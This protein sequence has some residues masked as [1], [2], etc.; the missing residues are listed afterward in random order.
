MIFVTEE[1]KA[2][3]KA[4]IEAET[5]NFFDL[6]RMAGIDPKTELRNTDL[7]GVDFTG[8]DLRGCDL[9]GSNLRNATGSQ[10]IW[11]STTNLTG[12]DTRGSIFEVAA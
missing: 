1:T 7:E 5:D 4:L 6:C 3:M 2:Q 8:C 9:S 10:A 12:A 11:D